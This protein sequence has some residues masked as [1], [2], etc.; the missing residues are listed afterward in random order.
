MGVWA[1]IITGIFTLLGAIGGGWVT[2]YGN[3]K[4]QKEKLSIEISRE[5]EKEQQ[6]KEIEKMEIYNS[7]LKV[8]GEHLMV[9]NVGG[10]YTELDIKV[11]QREI[12]PFLYQQLHLIDDDI[13]S[14]LIDIDEKVSE[15]DFNEEITSEE[16]VYLSR[17]YWEL[18]DMMKKHIDNFRKHFYK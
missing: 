14:I 7:V 17:K 12:R 9:T 10:H 3:G 16:Y 11:Y 2:A 13:A 6:Q 4:M 8:D 5:R 15:C 1:P 18:I